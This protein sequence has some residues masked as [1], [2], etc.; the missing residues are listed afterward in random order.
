MKKERIQSLETV[1]CFAFLGV[2]FSHSEL[3]VFKAAGHCGVSLFF[4]LSGFLFA[5]SYSEKST[6]KPS[7]GNNLRFAVNKVG[8]LYPTHIVC[9]VAMAVFCFAGIYRMSIS[10]FLVTFLLNIFVIQGWFPLND[11]SICGPSWY[12][13]AYFF[14][15]FVFPWTAFFNTALGKR[16]A[17]RNILLSLI[18]QLIIGLAGSVIPAAEYSTV[19][20]ITNDITKWFVYY[21]P[22]SRIFDFFIGMN[23]FVLFRE[24]ESKHTS[25]K[26][27]V[28]EGTGLMLLIAA[29]LIAVIFTR[30]DVESIS[31]PEHWWSLVL[32]FTAGSAITVYSFAANRGFFSKTLTNKLT[33]KVAGYSAHGFLL[34]FVIYNY[35]KAI[36]LIL[37]E[38]G[39]SA[40]LES[41]LGFIRLIFGTA[42]TFATVK[43]WET[44]TEKILKQL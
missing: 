15:C 7:F 43:I 3:T 22:L 36:V 14:A 20:W 18:I 40:M 31:H 8:R 19:M 5:L 29:Q 24:N 12:L 34:H 10:R 1:K 25:K 9:T 6:L 44:L 39:F 11:S 17:I 35:I 42:L 21:F 41:N 27:T 30:N 4:I 28:A 37:P 2:M 16:K 13:C 26:M 38:S 32:V 23:L 33:A